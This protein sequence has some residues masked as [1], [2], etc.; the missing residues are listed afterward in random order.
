L[1]SL[2][3][4]LSWRLLAS[5]MRASKSNLLGQALGQGT[6][7]DGKRIQ[8]QWL[9]QSNRRRKSV[10]WCFCSSSPASAWQELVMR[11]DF[12]VDNYLSDD[13]RHPASELGTNVQHEGR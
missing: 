8:D 2:G 3:R 6:R 13:Q 5:R 1:T 10:Y 9:R 11:D 12:L 4:Q 7:A